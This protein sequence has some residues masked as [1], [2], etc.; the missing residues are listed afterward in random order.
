MGADGRAGSAVVVDECVGIASVGGK[1]GGY[2]CDVGIEGAVIGFAEEL[3]LADLCS[4]V[5]YRQTIV[6][7]GRSGSDAID[8]GAVRI[9]EDGFGLLVYELP[10]GAV[11][12]AFEFPCGRGFGAFVGGDAVGRKLVVGIGAID[13]DERRR[14]ERC[15]N[16]V[17]ECF[18]AFGDCSERKNTVLQGYI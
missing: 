4:L 2:A 17:G 6:E 11:G 15:A 3:P 8:V 1:D 7:I 5:A 12:G 18:E 13:C 10:C 14:N 9:G 16:M